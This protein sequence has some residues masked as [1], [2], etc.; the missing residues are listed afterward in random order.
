MLA[1]RFKRLFFTSQKHWSLTLNFFGNANDL[2][3]FFFLALVVSAL[4]KA[5]CVNCF[6]CSTCN[7]K[8]TLKDKFV[9]IDLKP[10]CKH[11]YEKMPDEFKRRLAKREREAKE[12]E[13]QKKKKPICL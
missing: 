2:P 4:N 5:W 7:T 10:V 9:E 8:L 12:K 11:C 1:T 6:A 13:K 3:F